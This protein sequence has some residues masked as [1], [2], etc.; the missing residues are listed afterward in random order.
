MKTVTLTL[1][2]AYDI[3]CYTDELFV[4]SENLIEQRCKDPGGKG[5]NI[6]AALVPFGGS[7]ACVLL[8]REGRG[9]F[10]AALKERGIVPRVYLGEG[11]IRENITLHHKDGSET[12]ISFKPSQQ[13]Q[14]QLDLLTEDLGRLLSPGDILALA[15]SVPPGLDVEGLAR[16]MAGERERGVITLIDS[17]SF[18]AN[19]IRI[20]KPYLIKPNGEEILELCSEVGIDTHNSTE[21]M[22]KE[23]SEALGCGILHTRGGDTAYLCLAG[24]IWRAEPPSVVA[25]STVGAGDSTL[26]GYIYAKSREYREELC[27]RCAMAF[28]AA[29]CLTA[30]TKPPSP[31]D[32]EK[33]LGDGEITV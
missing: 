31:R 19:A 18:S 5:I 2:V 9:E 32:I 6:S 23:L 26:A 16:F 30:G 1:S 15:G 28:G 10:E 17:K 12:R 4:G 27:L 3:H 11:R 25:I 29:A 21:N 24:R 20:A 14:E 13:R 8:P 7:V 22:V 33:L